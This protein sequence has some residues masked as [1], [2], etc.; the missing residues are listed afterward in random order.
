MAPQKGHVFVR[1]MLLIKK[2]FSSLKG[3]VTIG[4][5]WDDFRYS[6]GSSLRAKKNEGELKIFGPNISLGYIGDKNQTERSFIFHQKYK[7]K[8]IGYKTGDIVKKTGFQKRIIFHRKKRYS[9]K[10]NGLQN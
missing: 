2:D 6:I 10:I 1:L 4:K 5:I 3:Y 7:N 8:I 9:N